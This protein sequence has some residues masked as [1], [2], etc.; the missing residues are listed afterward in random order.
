M[1][2]GRVHVDFPMTLR[3]T[4]IA[5]IAEKIHDWGLRYEASKQ[6]RAE[7]L[8]EREKLIFAARDA[9]MNIS[10]IAELTRLSRPMIY[11]ILD[12]WKSK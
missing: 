7:L 10:R 5:P 1:V 12:D 2:H 8:S 6:E 4:E 11:A 3:E 9:G